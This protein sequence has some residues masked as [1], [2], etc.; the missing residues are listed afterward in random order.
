MSPLSYGYG[1]ME[2]IHRDMSFLKT[3]KEIGSLIIWI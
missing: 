1:F 3:G 2:W